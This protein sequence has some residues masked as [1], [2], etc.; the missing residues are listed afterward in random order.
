MVI[1]HTKEQ[2]RMSMHQ[3]LRK[4]HFRQKLEKLGVKR[5]LKREFKEDMTDGTR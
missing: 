1:A 2:L 5:N 3:P 4:E